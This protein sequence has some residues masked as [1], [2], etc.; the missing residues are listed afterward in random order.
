MAALSRGDDGGTS[1]RCVFNGTERKKMKFGGFDLVS[2]KRWITLGNSTSNLSVRLVV[3]SGFPDTYP[4]SVRKS[5]ED[6]F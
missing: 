2:A 3:I 4:F 5:T 6:N 1:G